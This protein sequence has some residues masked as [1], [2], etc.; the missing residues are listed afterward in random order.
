ML[1][2]SKP[3]NPIKKALIILGSFM[4]IGVIVIILKIAYLH[5]KPYNS[6]YD[7]E[8]DFWHKFNCSIFYEQKCS[9]PL[10]RMWNYGCCSYL[11][12]KNRTSE[13]S[14]ENDLDKMWQ[15]SIEK[16]KEAWEQAPV[17]Y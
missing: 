12:N 16:E 6:N 2:F 13:E 7:T 9:N 11:K 4:M 3:Q 1:K 8:H 10:K 17:K 5:N 15:R 14:N